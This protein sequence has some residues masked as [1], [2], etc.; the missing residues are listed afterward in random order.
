VVTSRERLQLGGEHVYPVPVLAR[1]DARELFLTRA[2]ALR[3]D[4]QS[5][6]SVDELCARLDDLPLAL[7]LAAARTT[8]LSPEQLL[9]RLGARLDLLKGG[10]DADVRQQTLRAT[11]EWSHDL[12]DAAEQRLFA[13]LSLFRGGCTLEAAEAICGAELDELQSLVDKSLVRIRDGDR[14]WMLETIHEFAAERLRESGEEDELRRRH[15]EFF[16]ALAE[17]ANLSAE[18]TDLGP[19]PELVLPEQDNLWAALDWAAEAGEIELGLRLAIAL[20]QFWVAV[21]PYEGAR[22]VQAFLDR[23]ADLPDVVRARAIRVL[24]GMIFMTGDFDRGDEL[25]RQSL[26]LFRSLG[27]DAV[28]AELLVRLAIHLHYTHGDIAGAQ[29]LI[30]ESQ[31]IN[32]RVGSRSTEAMTLGLLGEIAWTEGRSDDALELAARSGEAA[33][34]VGFTWWQMHQLY[35]GS[36]WSGELGRTGE[37]EAY[38]RDALR[39]AVAIQDRQLTIYLLAILAGTAAV[40][41][42]LEKAGAVWGAIEAEEGRGPVGQWEAERE[43]YAAR[44][45]DHENE[46]FAAGR[47]RGRRMTLSDAVDYALADID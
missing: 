42:H 14:F 11:I 8:V 12:L 44:V 39:L 15:A 13:R 6:G 20:E 45:L 36:E 22:R 16:L 47:V 30:D 43:A 24:G 2:R 23:A 33:A 25:M 35:H 38:A 29:A 41:G 4:F 46:A 37:A 32:R 40:H 5:N 19:R 1:S 7:E 34:E 21:A 27:D 9:G 28:V 18:A 10:R 17:S 31:A 26:E 3:P